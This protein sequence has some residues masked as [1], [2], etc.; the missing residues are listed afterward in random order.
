MEFRLLGALEVRDGDK[1]IVIAAPKQRALLALLLLHHDERVSVDR[2]ADAL[3]GEAV[4]A[5]STKA[6]QVYIA[7]LRKALGDGV[8][9]TDA[10]GYRVVLNGHSLDVVR[11]ERLLND[12]TRLLEEGDPEAARRALEEALALWQGPA[13]PDLPD[14]DE[15]RRLEE[16]RLLALQRRIDADLALGRT[17]AA[18]AS[19][20]SSW[21]ASPCASARARS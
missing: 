20:R 11:F 6:V 8:V 14:E 16:E 15:G 10:S 19:F 7:Q 21:H 5:T 2:I 4:P 3:W 13:L 1:Q 9:L 12:G 17:I 18:S